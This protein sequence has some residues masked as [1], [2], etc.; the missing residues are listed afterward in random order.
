MDARQLRLAFTGAIADRE[1]TRNPDK[2]G[3]DQGLTLGVLLFPSDNV[4]KTSHR[5]GG[6][7]RGGTNA[8]TGSITWRRFIV[9]QVLPAPP[10][11][12]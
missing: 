4:Q 7:Q 5:K 11:G 12:V 9:Q 6:R 10:S 8:L 3:V 1:A 2:E